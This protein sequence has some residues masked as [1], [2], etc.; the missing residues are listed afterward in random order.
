M[1]R[2]RQDDRRIRTVDEWIGRIDYED[3]SFY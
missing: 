1:P 3:I 2:I